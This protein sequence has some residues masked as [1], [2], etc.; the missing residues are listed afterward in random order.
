MILLV[1]N[2]DSFVHNLARHFRLL[3]CETLVVRNDAIDAAGARS[4]APD[5]IVLS[6][7]PGAPRDA[8]ACIPIVREIGDTTPI[9]GICLGHQAI[10][11]ALGARV[12]R[13][14]APVHG[15]G[16]WVRHSGTDVFDGVAHPLSVGRYHS[17]AVEPTSLPPELTPTAWSDDG[18]LMA[19][20][21]TDRVLIGLQFHPES[22]L[23]GDGLRLLAN[24]LE[25]A[26]VS[27]PHPGSTAATS[28]DAIEPVASASDS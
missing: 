24:F 12:E 27:G 1:D 15:R 23:T 28:V 14:P 19:L 17:L 26:G 13:A 11:A 6:P 3:G 16:S 9:L 10:A 4:L 21:H 5:A 7:G 18:V 2:Y 8:G 20:R 25:I 22:V